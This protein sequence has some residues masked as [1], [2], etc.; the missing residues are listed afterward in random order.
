MKSIPTVQKGVR[1]SPHESM[2]RKSNSTGSSNDG[3][4]ASMKRKSDSTGSSNDGAN[5]VHASPETQQAKIAEESN[6][7]PL[8]EQEEDT[9]QQPSTALTES[10]DTGP[11]QDAAA[12]NLQTNPSTG[13]AAANISSQTRNPSNL[14]MLMGQQAARLSSPRKCA[15]N[16]GVASLFPRLLST[17]LAPAL[18]SP[19]R[20]PLEKTTAKVALPVRKSAQRPS[21]SHAA[22]IPQVES[23]SATSVPPAKANEKADLKRKA[24]SKKKADGPAKRKANKKRKA[25]ETIT[26][27]KIDSVPIKTTAETKT[28]GAANTKII[29]PSSSGGLEKTK[30]TKLTIEENI[31]GAA[32]NGRGSTPKHIFEN[33]SLHIKMGPRVE[34]VD[35]IEKVESADDQSIVMNGSHLS[36]RRYTN[37]HYE[38]SRKT[39]QNDEEMSPD[40]TDL[41]QKRR[42]GRQRK[43]R[44]PF[45]SRNKATSKVE[46]LE[47]P[48]KLQ[49]CHTIVELPDDAKAGEMLLVTWPV[50]RDHRFPQLFLIEIPETVPAP[51]RNRKRLL[52]VAAPGIYIPRVLRRRFG[53]DRYIPNSPMKTR[54]PVFSSPQ[55]AQ[56]TSFAKSTSRVGRLYQVPRFPP[57]S[58]F[59]QNDAVEPMPDG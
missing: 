12:E 55:K 16:P 38:P 29:A 51:R 25:N 36:F 21:K 56:W 11:L 22:Q 3:P 8:S 43:S 39:P 2:K 14:Q 13:A 46:R 10:A 32:N 42:S 47:F 4:Y 57:C 53:T 9:T 35:L 41:D 24:S 18:S 52:R 44:V 5:F 7:A 49:Q 34:F 17:C 40:E 23:D 27:A 33:H 1:T 48:T 28:D 31:S 59:Q 20:K 26:A 54:L 19:L 58:M 15:V 50:S 37:K 45:S 30:V 6:N